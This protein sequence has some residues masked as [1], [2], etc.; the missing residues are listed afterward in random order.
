MIGLG[1]LLFRQG[2]GDAA[3]TL[4]SSVDCVSHKV[5]P[6]AWSQMLKLQGQ[7]E[8]EATRKNN[9]QGVS[10]LCIKIKTVWIYLGLHRVTGDLYTKEAKR[11]HDL[12]HEQKIIAK[13]D[14]NMQ[15]RFW[16]GFCSM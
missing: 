5:S 6:S 12:S 4:W 10:C 11:Q 2:I 8:R 16:V 9:Q 7:Q 15:E 14:Y 13:P 1:Q 3:L